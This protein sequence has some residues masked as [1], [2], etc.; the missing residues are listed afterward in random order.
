MSDKGQQRTPADGNDLWVKQALTG[1][2]VGLALVAVAVI[3]VLGY[4]LSRSSSSDSGGAA[5]TLVRSDSSQAADFAIKTAAWNG[6]QRFVLSENRGKPTVLYFMA[7]WCV[8]CVPETQALARIH[9]EM[10]DEVTIIALDIDPNDT[11]DG[12]QTFKDVAEGADHLWAMDEGGVISQAFDVL[13]LD[14]TIIFDSDGRQVYRDS[15]PT[16]YGR[17]KSE[18]EKLL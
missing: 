15:A 9:K 14:T 17:L 2:A 3:I 6:G 13:T 10:G 5:S 18:L 16:P 7:S 1:A 11:E 4:A 8:T 12:L